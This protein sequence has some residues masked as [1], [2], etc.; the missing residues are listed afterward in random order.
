MHY[1]LSKRFCVHLHSWFFNQWWRSQLWANYHA[2]YGLGRDVSP[3]Y[4]STSIKELIL[5]KATETSWQY[6]RKRKVRRSVWINTPRKKKLP[7]SAAV[8]GK[9]LPRKASEY[10]AVVQVWCITIPSTPIFFPYSW[11]ENPIS[12]PKVVNQAKA[13]DSR[14]PNL[15]RLV[16]T[17]WRPTNERTLLPKNP[18]KIRISK[19]HTNRISL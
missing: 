4:S 10:R 2:S 19:I 18:T 9:P 6:N 17:I 8:L 7:L 5:N 1:W 14:P 11:T 3:T 12:S 15:W 16:A 13:R